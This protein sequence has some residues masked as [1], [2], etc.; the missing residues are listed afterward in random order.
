M[1][2][3]FRTRRSMDSIHTPPIS[4]RSSTSLDSFTSLATMEGNLPDDHDH[5]H[6]ELV[7]DCESLASADLRVRGGRSILYSIRSSGKSLSSSRTEVRKLEGRKA[8]VVACIERHDILPDTIRLRDGN[9]VRLRSWLRHDT[10]TV[11]FPDYGETH[12]TWKP[13][14][15]REIALFEEHNSYSPVAVFRTAQLCFFNGV[16][17]MMMPTLSLQP[18]AERIEELVL[19]SLLVVEEKYRIKGLG[20]TSLMS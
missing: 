9:T 1:D 6:T 12:Y 15:L 13:T 3:T 20:Q 14:G 5:G 10:F 4:S 2:S 18:E 7:F 17:V 16:N 8:V 19:A 11:S